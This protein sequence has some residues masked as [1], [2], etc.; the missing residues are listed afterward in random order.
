MRVQTL[1][2]DWAMLSKPAVMH[3]LRTVDMAS[4]LTVSR[5]VVSVLVP[6]TWSVNAATVANSCAEYAL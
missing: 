5:L 2:N 4:R 1:G 3:G 6:E